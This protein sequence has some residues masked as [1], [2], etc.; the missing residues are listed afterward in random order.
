MEILRFKQSF[1][2]AGPINN[3]NAI[4]SLFTEAS[5]KL[6]LER[7]KMVHQ[8][9]ICGNRSII[10]PQYQLLANSGFPI[11]EEMMEHYPI[12]FW[13]SHMWWNHYHN[14]QNVTNSIYTTLNACSQLT[15]IKQEYTI[16]K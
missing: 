12:M 5:V 1:I 2:V 13:Q 6:D 9:L 8:V 16:W 14:R 10:L 7:T 15:K 11:T 4:Y 3:V